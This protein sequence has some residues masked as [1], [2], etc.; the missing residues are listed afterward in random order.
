MGDPTEQAP[1]PWPSR[2]GTPGDSRAPQSLE[3]LSH[4]WQF[5]GHTCTLAT[6]MATGPQE[7]QFKGSSPPQHM[8]GDNSLPR[9]RHRE[10]AVDSLSWAQSQGTRRGVLG[11]PLENTG[12]S[13]QPLQDAPT[14]TAAQH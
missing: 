12:T 8:C 3:H 2:A 5:Q 14:A 1:C 13:Q 9:A 7:K 6:A 4:E 10:R 11:D